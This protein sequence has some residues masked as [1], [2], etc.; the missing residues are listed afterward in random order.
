LQRFTVH[1]LTT[2]GA[3]GL[4]FEIRGNSLICITESQ[5][6]PD[7]IV[8]AYDPEHDIAYRSPAPLTPGEL[9]EESHIH[10]PASLRNQIDRRVLA[11]TLGTQVLMQYTEKL[12]PAISPLAALRAVLEAIEGVNS[13]IVEANNAA[14]V[15]VHRAANSIE[16]VLS[17]Q[18]PDAPAEIILLSGSDDIEQNDVEPVV[19]KHI[20]IED[21]GNLCQFTEE[22]LAIVAE[23]PRHYTLAIGAARVYFEMICL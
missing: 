13:A 19:T 8:Q 21:F 22:S 3:L 5:G 23:S 18:K 11:S 7:I 20:S 1:S 6:L 14:F 17:S 9:E 4:T 10:I 16:A 15:T 2:H 12:A